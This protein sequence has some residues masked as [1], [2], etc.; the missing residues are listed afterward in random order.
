MHRT[1]RPNACC[2]ASGNSLGS[3]EE[4][5]ADGESGPGHRSLHLEGCLYPLGNREVQY[6]EHRVKV[7]PL[8]LFLRK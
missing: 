4:D 3:V 7:T 6:F 5:V 1:Q 2:V 8:N